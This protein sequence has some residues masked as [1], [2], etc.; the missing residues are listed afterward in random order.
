MTAFFW[1]STEQYAAS[2]AADK[3]YSDSEWVW[4]DNAEEAAKVDLLA[5]KGVYFKSGRNALER[6]FAK[7]MRENAPKW[8]CW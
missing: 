5:Y 2:D 8:L 4:F 7:I 1:V 6:L 3:G